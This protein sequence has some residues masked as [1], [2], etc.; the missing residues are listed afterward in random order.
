MTKRAI[1]HVDIQNDFCYGGL[2]AVTDG[3]SVVKQANQITEDAFQRG[4]LIVFSADC[5]PFITSHFEKWPPHCRKG[6]LGQKFHPQLKIPDGSIIV[7]KGIGNKDDGYSAFDKENVK[8]FIVV[9]GRSV[10]TSFKNLSSLLHFLKIKTVDV[11][12]LAT[13]YCDKATVLDAIRLNYRTR[14]ILDACRAVNL[15]PGDEEHAVEEMQDAGAVI[16][17]TE[18]VLNE[19]R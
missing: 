8:L 4:D 1:I 5:H 10:P 17:S 15:N 12:G 18:R 14:L 16:T 6:T 11:D 3:D 2:L 19:T 9:K 7:F 13:D